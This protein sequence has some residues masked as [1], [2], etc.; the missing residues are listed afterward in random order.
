MGKRQCSQHK[1]A[2]SLESRHM[3]ES[4]QGDENGFDVPV[5]SSDD[6]S[7]SETSLDDACQAIVD[8]PGALE[9]ST[10][11][12]SKAQ[13]SPAKQGIAKQSTPRHSK[14]KLREAKHSRV[15]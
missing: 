15:Q 13:R 4:E 7:L 3:V 6:S 2:Q 10:L 9:A 14:A 12:D 8:V 5:L 11:A 1:P